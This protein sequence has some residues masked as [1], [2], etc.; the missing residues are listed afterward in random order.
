[1]SG[2][3]L[4]NKAVADLK[5]IGRYTL[6]RWGRE[7]RDIYLRKLDTSFGQLAANPLNGKE[8]SEIREGY[9]K[10]TVGSHLILYRLWSADVIEIVRILH[11]RMDVEER[12]SVE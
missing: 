2:F 6:R 10:F 1:M 4:S 3:V 7:Q 11:G 12:M 9:R 5:D 8:C